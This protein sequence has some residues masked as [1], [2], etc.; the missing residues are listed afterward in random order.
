MAA[1]DLTSVAFIYKKLY[2]DRQVGD[3]A[4]R[5]HPFFSMV[6]KEGGFTGSNFNYPIRYGNPQG[7]SGA[8]ATAQT[9][10]SSS[11][12]VQLVATRKAKFAVIT[13][14]GEAIAASEGDRGAFM[15]LVTTETEGKIEELGDHL[16]FDS[17]RDG[18]C[19]RGRRSSIAGDVVTLTLADDARNFK[20][21]QTVIADDTATGLSPRTGSTTVA[22]VDEDAGT[23]TLTSAAAI[24]AFANSDYLFVQGEE[25]TGMEGLASHF[26]LAAPTAGDSFRGIDRSVDARRL[27]GV[28]VDDTA[29][30]IEENAGLVA[31][32]ISQVG[33][34]ADQLWLSPLNF[35]AVARRLNAKVELQGAGGQ[36]HYGFD[37][38][39]IHTAAGSLRCY[40]DPDC[41]PNRGYVLNSES[42]YIKH[43]RGLPHIVQDDGRPNLR[44]ASANGIE[45]RAASWCNLIVTLPGA[46]GV[47]SI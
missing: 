25:S 39:M 47:F 32:K 19:A 41:P 26:P 2:S 18:T 22:A 17:Y 10:A 7:I 1:S 20:V 4:M 8:F 44:Q 23:V 14:D 43:L 37:S 28:R 21:G 27:A 45:A 40:S 9:N 30:S 34:K 5:D 31:V 29:T 38:I 12:G 15:N 13:M 33:K 35:Y 42:M 36:A 11:K 3:L 6:A 46:N 16:A 24:V